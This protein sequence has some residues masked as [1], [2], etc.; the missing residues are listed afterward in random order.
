MRRLTTVVQNSLSS[1]NGSEEAAMLAEGSGEHHQMLIAVREQ[2]ARI[3]QTMYR[4]MGQMVGQSGEGEGAR[5]TDS[6]R[7]SHGTS[8]TGSAG[9][10][11]ANAA[12]L[13]L[14]EMQA[15]GRCQLNDTASAAADRQADQQAGGVVNAGE[16]QAAEAEAEQTELRS[17]AEQ[18]AAQQE[19][20]EAEAEQTELKSPIANLSMEAG[21]ENKAEQA[22]FEAEV[23]HVI[24]QAKK[25]QKGRS[26]HK[27]EKVL[28]EA[29]KAE[30]TREQ[31]D[32]AQ[33][34]LA[35]GILDRHW[36]LLEVREKLDR[37]EWVIFNVNVKVEHQHFVLLKPKSK[38][39]AKRTGHV[40]LKG[41]ANGLCA[42][43]AALQIAK[44]ADALEPESSWDK[45][46]DEQTY[47]EFEILKR[48]Q[49][50]ASSRNFATLMQ[51]EALYEQI[52][53]HMHRGWAAAQE[54][55]TQP[56]GRKFN[57]RIG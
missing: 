56:A 16:L 54:K 27:W 53:A 35:L 46:G 38:T 57:S 4:R 34:L 30:N 33:A 25:I 1:D 55:H 23:R 6:L 22:R 11:A 9:I 51:V 42:F 8:V 31:T 37:G 47:T 43:T 24:A 39:V 41:E 28:R 45:T 32:V 50:I 36:Q 17:P 40:V 2:A 48:T 3:A 7:V 19:A 14:G 52:T 21:D 49:S 29:V 15:A 20:A 13:A 5:S 18:E 12:A 44:A 26:V 10:N